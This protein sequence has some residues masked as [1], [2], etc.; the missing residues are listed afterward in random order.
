VT[1]RAVDEAGIA[2]RVEHFLMRP[3]VLIGILV[4]LAAAVPYVAARRHRRPRRPGAAPSEV[5]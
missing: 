2:T 1:A 5:A 4:L 3:L